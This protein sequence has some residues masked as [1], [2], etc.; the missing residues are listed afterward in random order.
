M[1][2]IA[3]YIVVR[4]LSPTAFGLEAK[5]QNTT[6]LVEAKLLP[7]GYPA[8]RLQMRSGAIQW[9]SNLLIQTV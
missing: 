1:R 7:E 3:D 5:A 9:N 6:V 2:L 4:A 8:V